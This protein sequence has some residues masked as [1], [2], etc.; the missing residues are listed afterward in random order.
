MDHP[1]APGPPDG[2]TNTSPIA[3]DAEATP[4]E[5]SRMEE[6]TLNEKEGVTREAAVASTGIPFGS[7]IAPI[8]ADPTVD[9]LVT[10]IPDDR[11][12][13]TSHARPFQ[14][15]SAA[16]SEKTLRPSPSHSSSG[17]SNSIR[18]KKRAFNFGKNRKAKTDAEKKS[19]EKEEEA[20]AMPP[21]GFLTLYRFARPH[22]KIL[23]IIAMF[24]AI[25][26]GAAQPLMTLI[27]G[28]FTT[29]ITEF[30]KISAMVA[31]VNASGGTP[32]PS[33]MAELEMA[34]HQLRI[35]SGHNALY[36][37]AIGIGIFFTTFMYMF[38]F[39][40]TGELMA[41]RIRQLYLKAVLRQDVS[42]A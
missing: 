37:M 4:A 3:E 23:N 26:A 27:F 14:S 22:E 30:G 13:L 42:V 38:I 19:K 29:S 34:K 39:N 33:Q 31:Q 16:V 25:A 1:T 17:S 15:P 12:P 21:V 18:K 9:A 2:P 35:D 40:W 28:R 10:A 36:L 8:S 32:S 5:A 41:K 20:A 6:I 7:S 24:M 11:R